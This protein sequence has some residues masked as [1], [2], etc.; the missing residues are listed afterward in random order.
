MTKPKKTKS[1]KWH[2]TVYLGRDEDGRRIYKSVTA[3]QTR[4]K[5]AIFGLLAGVGVPLISDLASCLHFSRVS[6]VTLL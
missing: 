4:G 6:A 1:G 2:L 5:S 3:S